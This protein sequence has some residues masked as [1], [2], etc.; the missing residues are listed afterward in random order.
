MFG[1]ETTGDDVL[2][3]GAAGGAGLVETGVRA[4]GVETEDD[5][6]D[7]VDAEEGG[8]REDGL[9]EAAADDGDLP[10]GGA[11]LIQRGLGGW[12]DGRDVLL[13]DRF[14]FGLG[15]LDDVEALGEDGFHRRAAVHG[16]VGHV[17]DSLE[18]LRS[19]QAA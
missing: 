15:R 14:E 13:A 16:R 5:R 6:F 11:E 3:L 18:G 7:A 2:A 1:A 8:E 9:G 4:V 12:L 10:A 19:A 17:F